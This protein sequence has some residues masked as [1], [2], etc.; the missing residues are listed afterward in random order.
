MLTLPD[1]AR[2]LARSRWDQALRAWLIGEEPRLQVPIRGGAVPEREVLPNLAAYR[3]WL[4]SWKNVPHV[5]WRTVR[6]G[7]LGEVSVP[8]FVLPPTIDAYADWAGTAEDLTLIRDRLDA[9]ARFGCERSGLARV[10]WDLVDMGDEEFQHLLDFLTWRRDCPEPTRARDVPLIGVG[11]KWVENRI[12]LIEPLLTSCGLDRDGADRFARCGLI[13]GGGVRLPLRFDPEDFPVLDF[14]CDPGSFLRWPERTHTLLII[15][16]E[17]PF[18]TLTPRPG[19]ALAW[20]SGHA[21]RAALPELPVADQLR[22]LY[23]GDCDSHGYA[24]LNGLRRDLPHLRPVG[25]GTDTVQAHEGALIP[26][27]DPERIETSM[28]FLGPD[29]A[30]ARMLLLGRRARL[31]QERVRVPEADLFPS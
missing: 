14:D 10:R 16:N 22:L 15:E 2:A 8:A 30:M 25:M 7:G 21:A 20:G 23:W 11:S 29:E 31:E 24:I 26:E 28:P 27:A 13:R 6:K 1:E 17:A 19:Y 5:G 18:R 4:L 3:D 12:G 9:L